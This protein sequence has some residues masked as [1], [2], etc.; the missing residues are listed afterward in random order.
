MSEILLT[1]LDQ[2]QG[3]FDEEIKTVDS[4]PSLESLRVKYLARKGEVMQYFK[5]LGTLD[6]QDR[7][8]V[9]QR[10]NQLKKALESA[11]EDKKQAVSQPESKAPK[12]DL[13]LP[14]IRRRLGTRH[15]LLQTLDHIKRIFMDMGFSVASGPLAET[16]Y[17]NF[18]ALNI[19]PDHPS[20]DMQDTFY[21][22]DPE[23]SNG[24]VYLLRTHTSPVQVHTMEAMQPPIRIIA[25]GR[26]FRKDTP[27]ATHSPVFHQV[28][29]LWVDEGVSM[30]DLKG[31]LL[32]FARALLGK[33][34]IK[35]RFRPSFFP[36]TEPSAELDVWF[37]SKNCWL[38]MLGCGMV[39]P[40]VFDH[41]GIDAEK[42]TG[43]AFGM[44]VERLAMMKYGIDDI[45]VFFD[46]DVR[47]IRQF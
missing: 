27:D 12:V 7:P 38:E 25:P 16:D 40:N 6:P 18:E 1:E 46:N 13:T 42:Y 35:A 11:V 26:V 41:V 8:V 33:D 39:D 24:E 9:G 34:D 43:F 3:R 36:F 23:K 2:I 17:Y 10:L 30:A 20:R 22:S 44:G 21:L 14:G 45:R 4:E 5:K 37:E 29:G 47:F 19:P 32:A 28:E 15:P 31:V